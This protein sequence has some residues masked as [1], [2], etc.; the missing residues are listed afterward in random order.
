MALPTRR[1][2]ILVVQAGDRGPLIA[3]GRNARNAVRQECRASLSS[4]RWANGYW[5]STRL[6]GD[7]SPY[8]FSVD[9]SGGTR[10]GRCACINR[11]PLRVP[12]HRHQSQGGTTLLSCCSVIAGAS[13]LRRAQQSDSSNCVKAAIVRR[14]L[15]DRAG[16]ATRVSRLL[17]LP[18]WR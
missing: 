5:R 15:P 8:Q 17:V 16:R 2:D 14:S 1:H 18:R 3:I 7:A 4:S 11:K 10:A 9:G 12:L 6:G 13:I